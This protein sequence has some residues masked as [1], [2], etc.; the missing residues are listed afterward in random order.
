MRL[1]HRFVPCAISVAEHF[2]GLIAGNA[3]DKKVSK[4][5]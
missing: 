2:A 5:T 3:I 1:E 4:E